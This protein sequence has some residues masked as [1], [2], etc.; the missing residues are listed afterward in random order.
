[1]SHYL[2]ASVMVP[3]FVSELSSDA[4]A[5]WLAGQ[6]KDVIASRLAIAETTSAISRRRRMGELTDALGE[7]AL[8]ALD[9]WCASAATIIDHIGAD[10]AQAARLVRRPLPKL[11][12][13]DAIHLATCRRLGMTLVTNDRDLA[14]VAELEGVDWVRP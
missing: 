11:L 9:S 1:L 5:K 2:D 4:M 3:L 6:G 12:A 8:R 10:I 13:P 14:V 7:S